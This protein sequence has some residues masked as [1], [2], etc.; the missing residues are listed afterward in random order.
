MLFKGFEPAIQFRVLNCFQGHCPYGND[1]LY[2]HLS[3]SLEGKEPPHVVYVSTANGSKVK[4]LKV[5]HY[6]GFFSFEDLR[7]WV[8]LHSGSLFNMEPYWWKLCLTFLHYSMH[9]LGVLL[10]RIGP[11]GVG[12]ILS[13]LIL[14]LI[15]AWGYLCESFYCWSSLRRKQKRKQQ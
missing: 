6:F 8:G 7:V 11:L 5:V 14:S 10:E 15:V 12:F 13:G 4:Q 2:K 9:I 1:E 3:S